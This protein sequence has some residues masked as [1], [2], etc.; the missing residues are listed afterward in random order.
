MNRTSYDDLRELAPTDPVDAEGLEVARAA[1][2]RGRRAAER[3]TATFPLDGGARPVTSRPRRAGQAGRVLVALTAGVLL[4]V[5][6]TVGT[7]LI[8]A[9]ARSVDAGPAAGAT[10]P[11]TPPP[12][13]SARP[14]DGP[15]VQCDDSG[16]GL[17]SAPEISSSEWPYLLDHGWTL[18]D[19]P[20]TAPPTLQGSPVECVGSVA[21]VVFADPADDRAVV[22][23]ER[24]P[25]A[26][27]AAPGTSLSEAEIGTVGSGDHNVAWTDEHGYPWFA[28]AG[29]VSVAEFRTV[30]DSLVYREDGSVTGP[31]PDGFERV[32]TPDTEPGTTL[33]LWTMWHGEAMSYLWATWPV[34]TPIEAGI[35]DGRDYTAVDFD[36]GTALYSGGIEGLSANPPSL[37][38]ERDGVRFWLLDSG[39]DLETLKARARSVRPLDFDSPELR[40]FLGR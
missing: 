31:V 33:Y 18:P 10:E 15:A 9:I 1:F 35:A 37:K 13:P 5:A 4:V 30:L 40:P 38:W 32:E 14:G 34:T 7:V 8:R 25:G 21:S 20:L 16:M 3:T 29:G 23:Y 22:V 19:V 12:S 26:L 28:Q 36:G 2:E 17:D 27:P 6:G 24:L 11:R 39:A